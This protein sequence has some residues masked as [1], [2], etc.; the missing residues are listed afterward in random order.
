M[1]CKH[2]SHRCPKIETD[3]HM[4]SKNLLEP[5]H[6]HYLSST[7]LGEKGFSYPLC[8]QNLSWQSQGVNMNSQNCHVEGRHG[9]QF[10]WLVLSLACTVAMAFLQLSSVTEGQ[11]LKLASE[12]NVCAPFLQHFPHRA[13]WDLVRL[14][15]FWAHSWR[16]SSFCPLTKSVTLDIYL[17]GYTSTETL[18]I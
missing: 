14:T 8:V 9:T 10:P 5:T 11:K 18:Q 17:S 1:I 6:L 3:F 4:Q 2:I 15:V 16:V 12:C 7:L 13:Q